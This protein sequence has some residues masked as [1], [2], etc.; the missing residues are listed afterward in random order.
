MAEIIAYLVQ[1]KKKTRENLEDVSQPLLNLGLN[2]CFA[3]WDPAG[4]VSVG[5]M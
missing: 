2:H 1:S 4:G 3:N 5:M